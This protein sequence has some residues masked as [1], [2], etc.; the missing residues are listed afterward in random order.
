MALPQGILF[1][2]MALALPQ[3]QGL[4]AIKYIGRVKG[5]EVKVFQACDLRNQLTERHHYDNVENQPKFT[6]FI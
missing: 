5:L 1:L 6:E 3:I 2:F 4:E